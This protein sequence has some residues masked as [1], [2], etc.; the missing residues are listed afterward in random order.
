VLEVAEGKCVSHRIY[1]DQV[2]MLT[3]LGLMLAPSGAR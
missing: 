2:E 3:Q 1:Y